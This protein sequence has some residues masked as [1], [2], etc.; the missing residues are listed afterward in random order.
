MRRSWVL[1]IAIVS[2]VVGLAVGKLTGNAEAGRDRATPGSREGTQT[3]R[4]GHGAGRGTPS[5]EVAPAVG[6]GPRARTFDDDRGDGP[7]ERDDERVALEGQV[8]TTEAELELEK[9]RA[10]VMQLR[11]ERTELMGSSIDA[12][13]E[14]A[15]RFSGPT[16]SSAIAGAL[17]AEKIAGDVEGTDCAEYPC[18]VFGRLEGDEEDMEEIERSAALSPYKNDVLTLLFWATSVEEGVSA[19]VPETG[20]FALAFYTVQE[21]AERGD[22]LDRRIRAR[23]MEYWNTDRPGKR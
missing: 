6:A 17:V 12:P 13:A 5:R 18:I 20:L 11:E 4:T 3:S 1:S 19:K 9:L 21:R 22:Q 23:V 15:P 7:D 14:S 10:Q 8:L 16:M 2:A